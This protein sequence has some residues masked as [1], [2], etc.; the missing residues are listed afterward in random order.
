MAVAVVQEWAATNRET[1]GYDQVSAEIRR[2]S[3]GWPEGL[4]FQCAGF[5][6]DTF[7]VF[8]AWDAREYFDRFEREVLMPAVEAAAP[9]DGSPP[10]T[11]SYELHAAMVPQAG[12]VGARA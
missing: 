3:S 7:R 11:H 10:Q 1:R 9:A 4:L 8:S 2:R 6:G 12:Q 5:D